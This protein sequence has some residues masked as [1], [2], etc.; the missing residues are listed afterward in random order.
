MRRRRR[1]DGRITGSE[2]SRSGLVGFTFASRSLGATDGHA[3][4]LA[5]SDWDGVS[6]ISTFGHTSWASSV[7]E[8]RTE[9]LL[10]GGKLD[11][12]RRS[13]DF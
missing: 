5:R 11:G 9:E 6:A 2:L 1:V 3:G 13:L 12:P 7:R 10:V 4:D 8:T